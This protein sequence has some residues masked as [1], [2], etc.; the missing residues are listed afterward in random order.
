MTMRQWA[1]C[2]D[3][4]SFCLF[5]AQD[6]I[7]DHDIIGYTAEYQSFHKG[8]LLDSKELFCRRMATDLRERSEMDCFP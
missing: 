1:L 7:P 6:R 4:G 5:F 2:G 3:V 8:Q